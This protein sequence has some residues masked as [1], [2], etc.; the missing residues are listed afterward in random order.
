M[1]KIRIREFLLPTT[2]PSLSSFLSPGA[3]PSPSAVPK[4]PTVPVSA[5]RTAPAAGRRAKGL[6]G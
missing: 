5:T 3:V 1:A 6:S 4:G 2:A